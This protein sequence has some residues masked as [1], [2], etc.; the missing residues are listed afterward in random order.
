M[1]SIKSCLFLTFW[2]CVYNLFEIINNGQVAGG[3][4][5]ALGVHTQCRQWRH[6]EDRAQGIKLV[7]FQNKE[8]YSTNLID[9]F[10]W[11]TDSVR[12][13][14][15]GNLKKEVLKEL[16]KSVACS[17]STAL[18]K[19]LCKLQRIALCFLCSRTR[20]EPSGPFQSLVPLLLNFALLACV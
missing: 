9:L 16:C 8:N 10:K 5:M 2:S 12:C 11:E 18:E 13:H 1:Q 15:L 4:V 17:S 14:M 3:E 19:Q 20:T 6:G 7:H